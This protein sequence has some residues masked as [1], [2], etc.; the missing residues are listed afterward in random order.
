ME[1]KGG[2]SGTGSN[3]ASTSGVLYDPLDPL[4]KSGEFIPDPSDTG[5]F[6]LTENEMIQQDKQEMKIKRK[7]KHTGLKVFIV[8]VLIVL[9]AGRRR[10]LR[11]LPR[12]WASPRSK[13]SS[14][15][16]STT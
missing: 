14:R 6:T 8:I 11:L 13:R 9:I 2:L 16:C 5:F 15:A 4:G 7:R 1:G 3:T 12:L 10:L